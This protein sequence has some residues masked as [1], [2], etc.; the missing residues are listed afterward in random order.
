M[1]LFTTLHKE[2]VLSLEM[3][4]DQ[5]EVEVPREGWNMKMIFSWILMLH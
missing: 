3:I 1:Q 4:C 5:F 2:F